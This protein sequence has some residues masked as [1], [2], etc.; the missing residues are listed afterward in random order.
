MRVAAEIGRILVPGDERSVAR[1]LDPEARAEGE[2]IGPD[3]VL[4]RVEDARLADQVP[5]LGQAEMALQLEDARVDALVVLELVH[6]A[7]KIVAFF[8]VDSVDREQVSLALEEL[9]LVFGQ[10][11]GHTFLRYPDGAPGRPPELF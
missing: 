8:L 1:R 7:E 10:N 2:N 6:R 9:D 4:G 5:G 11:L 3:D